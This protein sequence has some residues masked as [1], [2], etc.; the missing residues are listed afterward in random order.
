MEACRLI[1]VAMLY[2][3]TGN[4]SNAI[5]ELNKAVEVCRATPNM[6][7]KSMIALA[8]TCLS[9]NLDDAATEVMLGV[10]SDINSDVT[11][12]QAMKIFERAGR[13]DLAQKIS[14]QLAQQVKDLLR[15]AQ[16][17]AATGDLRGAVA[18]MQDAVHRAPENSV[19]LSQ[20]ASMTM[21]QLDHMGWEHASGEQVRLYLEQI[22]RQEP[23]FEKMAELVKSYQTIQRKYGI[24]V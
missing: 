20:A 22:K 9:Q 17:K 11:M 15:Q 12:G 2:E 14:S 3:A 5:A 19:V 18:L 21:R 24:A 1:S 13:A 4:A 7:S 10:T 23:N 6:S 16:E 8:K